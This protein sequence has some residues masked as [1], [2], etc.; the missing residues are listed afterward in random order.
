[1][2][3]TTEQS[4]RLGEVEKALR[5]AAKA[6][7]GLT[8]ALERAE[9]VTRP[10]LEAKR[11]AFR[12]QLR[13]LEVEWAQLARSSPERQALFRAAAGYD[14]LRGASGLNQDEARLRKLLTEN[15]RRA[16]D[17]GEQFEEQ[18]RA[19]TIRHIVPEIGSDGGDLHILNGVRLGAAGVEFDFVVARRPR[20]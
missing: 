19:I 8:T 7:A 4:A 3:A 14:R 11:E 5:N 15:G 10:A 13:N 20:D 1:A 6:I 17:A 18:A 9:D 16:G 12:S 2:D